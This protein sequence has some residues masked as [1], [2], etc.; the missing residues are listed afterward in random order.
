MALKNPITNEYIKIIDVSIEQK[1]V[2]YF[3]FSNLEQRQRYENGLS[4]YENFFSDAKFDDTKFNLELSKLADGLKSV[5]E[6]MI[7]SGYNFLMQA[8]HIE[9]EN[10]ACE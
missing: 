10:S 9:W 8:G 1:R 5:K 4:K 6:N 7:I 3:V 2:A